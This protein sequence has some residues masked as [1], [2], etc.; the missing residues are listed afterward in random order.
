MIWRHVWFNFW[1]LLATFGNWWQLCCC[2]CCFFFFFSLCRSLPLEFLRSSFIHSPYV[3]YLS[4][5]PFSS[6]WCHP[7]FW[8]VLSIFLAGV[9]PVVSSIDRTG[10]FSNLCSLASLSLSLSL[11]LT[12]KDQCQWP[13]LRF[14]HPAGLQP[15]NT[16]TT[17]QVRSKSRIKKQGSGSKNR[18]RDQGSAPK[19]QK[20]QHHYASTRES[21]SRIRTKDQIPGRQAQ[22]WCIKDQD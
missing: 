12:D 6:G 22:S 5:V 14:S 13:R 21:G 4:C 17:K 7:F 16:N 19:Y 10:V 1:K 20:N 3:I 15:Q 11:S 8:L 9:T 2:C 18:I